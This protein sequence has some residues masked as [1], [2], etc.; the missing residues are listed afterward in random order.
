[1]RQRVPP[2]VPWVSVRTYVVET[3]EIKYLDE[4]VVVDLLAKDLLGCSSQT[5]QVDSSSS[6]CFLS[7]LSPVS[8]NF[9]AL[10]QKT[11]PTSHIEKKLVVY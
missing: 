7:H 8:Q 1:V 2:V 10:R 6:S 11:E 9:F 5:S 3:A 4:Q